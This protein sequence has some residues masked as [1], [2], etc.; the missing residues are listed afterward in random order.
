MYTRQSGDLPVQ[1]QYELPYIVKKKS[2]KKNAS[3]YVFVRDVI[4]IYC[5][6]H[7]EEAVTAKH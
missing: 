7:P 4:Y 6:L 5:L 1:N 3:R 2:E